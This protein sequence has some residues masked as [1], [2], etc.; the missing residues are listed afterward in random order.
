MQKST[1]Q[2]VV[3]FDGICNFCNASVNY[4]LRKD[5]TKSIQFSMLQSDF[6]QT[7]LYPQITNT[8]SGDYLLYIRANK[9][10]KKS[11]AALYI[12]KDMKFFW[13]FLFYLKYIPKSIRDFFYMLI[14]KNRYRI[15]GKREQCRIP[16]PEERNRFLE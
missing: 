7:L 10:Y 9:L 12:L 14:A 6:A 5:K 2:K 13:S 16:K 4:I 15:F 11:D 1:K 8:S 3:F